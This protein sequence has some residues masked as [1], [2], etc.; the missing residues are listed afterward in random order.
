MEL[1]VELTYQNVETSLSR[2]ELQQEMLKGV[3][4]LVCEL[5]AGTFKHTVARGGFRF[6]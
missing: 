3:A 6:T 1:L 4:C 5:I 2:F